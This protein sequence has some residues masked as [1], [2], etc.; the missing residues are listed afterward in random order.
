MLEWSRACRNS[1]VP[2]KWTLRDTQRL[3]MHEPGDSVYYTGNNGQEI[4]PERLLRSRSKI[5]SVRGSDGWISL[6]W[7]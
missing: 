6:P 2:G 3:Y 7:Q 4:L 1:C 5:P